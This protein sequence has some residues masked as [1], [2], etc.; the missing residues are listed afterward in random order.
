[1]LTSVSGAVHV[2]T[3]AQT[4]GGQKASDA[5]NNILSCSVGASGQD[6]TAIVCDVCDVF[7]CVCT[8]K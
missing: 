5:I 7:V 6:R 2:C 3:T 8:S 4:D 1:M